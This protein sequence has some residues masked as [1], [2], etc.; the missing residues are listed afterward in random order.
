MKQ[1]RARLYEFEMDKK[2]AADKKLED[3]KLDI[4][5]GSQIRSYVLAP[6]RMI[7]DHRTKLSI[8]DVDRVLDGDLDRLTHAFLVFKHT[9][10]IAG[11]GKEETCLIE[12][13]EI[14]RA[15]ALIRAGDLVAFPTETVYGLGAN[16]LDAAAVRKIFI[17]KGRPAGSPLIVHVDSVEMAQG[18]VRDWPATADLLARRFWPGPLT[19]VL[20]KQ[21]HVPDVLTAGLDTVGV[22]MPANAIAYRFDS[23]SRRSYRRPQREPFHRIVAH[24]GRARS[25]KPR[26]SGSHCSGRGPGYRW[27]RIH[28]AFS[29]GR[30]AAI[31]ET[32]YVDQ[33]RDRRG[34]WPVEVSGS[35]VTGAHPSPGMHPRHYSPRTPLILV[36]SGRLPSSGRGAYLWISAAAEAAR[37]IRMPENS[38]DYAAVL[39]ATLHGVDQQTGLDRS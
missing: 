35:S 24:H 20:P 12:A 6:Y 36:E 29:R 23:G 37:V 10:K 3:T 5:F 19:L 16:A 38:R 1:M 22:R 15:A 17:A 2:R 39:Y 7:K 25:P 21:P 30:R 32:G 34:H 33:G 27:H 14:S 8:G 18:L 26:R 31:V 9:G 28:S 11:D 4:N 13:S